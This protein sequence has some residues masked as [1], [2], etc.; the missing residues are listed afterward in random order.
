[1]AKHTLPLIYAK[2]DR[3][4]GVAFFKNRLV[5]SDFIAL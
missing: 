3:G 2:K 5:S 4:C 1:M